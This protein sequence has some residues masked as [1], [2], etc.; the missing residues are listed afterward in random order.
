MT[1]T[2]YRIRAGIANT[3]DVDVSD[4]FFAWLCGFGRKAKIMSPGPVV[5]QFQEYLDKIREMY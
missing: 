1:S 3:I 4:Q 2:V 5:E